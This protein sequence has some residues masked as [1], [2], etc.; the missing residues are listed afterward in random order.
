MVAGSGANWVE[1]RGVG[2][3]DLRLGPWAGD[4]WVEAAKS[5]FVWMGCKVQILPSQPARTTPPDIPIGIYI[6]INKNN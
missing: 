1:G 5:N 3:G 4:G 6:F 2:S